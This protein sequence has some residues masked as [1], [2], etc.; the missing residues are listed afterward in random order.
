M[1]SK[2]EKIRAWLRTGG[3]SNFGALSLADD[4]VYTYHVRLAVLDRETRTANLNMAN[5]SVTSSGHRN[6]LL[7]AFKAEG[8]TVVGCDTAEDL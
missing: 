4:T 1:T 8:Y 3:V 2:T 6:R 5:Y 7:E